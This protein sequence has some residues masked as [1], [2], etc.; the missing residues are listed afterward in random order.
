MGSIV[1]GRVGTTRCGIQNTVWGCT[2]NNTGVHRKGAAAS[3]GSGLL[4]GLLEG[5]TSLGLIIIGG[6]PRGFII[7]KRTRLGAQEEG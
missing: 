3:C 4:A 2:Y 6:I 7:G 5:G 1:G